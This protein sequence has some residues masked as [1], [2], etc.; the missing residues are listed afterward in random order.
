MN[1]YK[2]LLVVYFLL[3]SSISHASSLYNSPITIDSRIKTLVYSSNEVFTLVFS[4]GYYSYIEFSEA[5][6]IKSIAIGDA[7]NWKFIP[8]EN[9]LFVM[10]LEVS[11]RTNMIITTNKKR[12]YI[13]D[14]LSRPNYD[15]VK[16]PNSEEMSHDYSA[17]RDISY[18]VRFYYPK[19]ED[20]FD[21]ISDDVNEI[22]DPS[23]AHLMEQV[24]SVIQE[25]NSKHNYV[26]KDKGYDMDL[27]PLE[28]FDDGYLTYF[29]FRNINDIPEILIE[30]ENGMKLLCK[31]LLLGDYV[32]I[33]G[34]HKKLF[35]RYTDKYI[36]IINRAL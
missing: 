9:R 31:M 23:Q 14:L 4:Q 25:N 30:D 33:K 2:L 21:V 28:L 11:S 27:I 12:N 20:E 7:S 26:Y 5:E 36:K 6:R 15:K 34:V 32:I 8:V 16:L 18:V 17:E 24:D 22:S 29:K 35:M 10:P 19:A 13:F 3:I 1:I